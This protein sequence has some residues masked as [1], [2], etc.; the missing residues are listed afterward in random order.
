MSPQPT[1]KSQRR[2][3]AATVSIVLS[4]LGWL[5]PF[6]GFVAGM[7]KYGPG[8]S[9]APWLFAGF[10]AIAT[11]ILGILASAICLLRS[12]PSGEGAA[13][14]TWLLA[15]LLS[16]PLGILGCIGALAWM[17]KFFRL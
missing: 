12:T 10:G 3:V 11:C 1:G 2:P 16:Y 5:S 14:R 6:V 8:W 17:V 9:L 13:R 4:V 7:I 15:K